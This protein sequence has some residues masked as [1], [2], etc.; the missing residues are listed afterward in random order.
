MTGRVKVDVP[1]PR[2]GQH[3]T[4]LEHGDT[5]AVPFVGKL[6]E[7]LAAQLYGRPESPPALY[8]GGTKCVR[9]VSVRTHD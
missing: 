6:G 8:G 5:G 9:A 3:S 4:Q 2:P 7:A 1:A